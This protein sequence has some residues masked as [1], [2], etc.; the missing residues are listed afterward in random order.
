MNGGYVFERAWARAQDAAGPLREFRNEFLIP[1]HGDG[2]Q[3]YLCGNSL[4][5]Q[6]RATRQALQEVRS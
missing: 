3:V 1:P 4:G 6:P 2:E 5:L